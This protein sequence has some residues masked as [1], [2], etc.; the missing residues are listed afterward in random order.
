VATRLDYH[1]SP[2]FLEV[3]VRSSTIKDVAERAGV[4]LKTVSR[5]VNREASVHADTRDKVQRAIDE[6]GYWPD[7]SAR[8]LR[9]PHAFSLGLVYDNPNSHYVIDVQRGAL[10]ACR[11][12]G[13]GL[14]IHPCDAHSG[15]LAEELIQLTERWRLSGLVLAPPM[16]EAEDILHALTAAKIP[17]ERIISAR[18]DPKDGFPCVYVDDRDAA[19]MVTEHLIQLGHQRIAFL[20]GDANHRSSPERCRG[21]EDALKHYGIARDKKFV[22]P[23]EYTFDSGFRRTRKLL[24]RRDRPTAVIGAN[25]EIAAGV[26]A[27]ARSIGID[28]PRELSIAGFEDSPFSRQSWPALTTIRQDTAEMVRRASLRLIDK[29]GRTDRQ[30][31]ANEGFQP[32]LVIRSST[33]TPLRT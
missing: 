33:T 24:A 15:Q 25:D 30:A 10:S 11:E 7:P 16:S 4:S 28:V 22:M 27:A 26:L 12:R 3:G 20:W 8:G 29:L 5:V 6:L 1:G 13:F 18:T 21:Y 9:S 2:F 23:G 19:Y 14:Q 17:F 32:E 31:E